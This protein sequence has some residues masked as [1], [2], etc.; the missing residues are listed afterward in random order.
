MIQSKRP[1]T[2]TLCCGDLCLDFNNSVY[3]FI[4][5]FANVSYFLS[6]DLGIVRCDYDADDPVNI[7]HV[8]VHVSE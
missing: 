1:T 3:I 4:E 5:T 8:S 7:L 6:P 2:C